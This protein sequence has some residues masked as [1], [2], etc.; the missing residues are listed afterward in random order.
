MIDAECVEEVLEELDQEGAPYEPAA[1]LE[2]KKSEENAPE[3]MA[4]ELA[5]R[6]AA[7]G[8]WHVKKIN[9]SVLANKTVNGSGPTDP[10]AFDV[11]QD[12]WSDVEHWRREAVR[13]LHKLEQTNDDLAGERRRVETMRLET[14]QLRE[15]LHKIEL[16]QTRAQAEMARRSAAALART[17]PSRASIFRRFGGN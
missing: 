8:A 1:P 3:P 9:G 13:L 12:H 15:K 7:S 14:E 16:E 4:V 2:P 11:D 5:E 6:A 17:A 10:E